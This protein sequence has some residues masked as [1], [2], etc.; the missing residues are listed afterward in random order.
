M[1]LFPPGGFVTFTWATRSNGAPAPPT[2]LALGCSTEGALPPAAPP[3]RARGFSG[4]AG[5]SHPRF[6]EDF[7]PTVKPSVTCWL[8]HYYM[9]S[10]VHQIS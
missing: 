10:S 1:L 8:T 2:G 7:P 6:I 5:S 4:L 3:I 9:S